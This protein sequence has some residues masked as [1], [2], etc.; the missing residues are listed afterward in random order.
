MESLRDTPPGRRR[1]VL[2]GVVIEVRLGD[3]LN[4]GQRPA[5]E[6]CH[7][8]LTPLDVLLQDRASAQTDALLQ[9]PAQLLR[10]WAMV[11]PMEEPLAM[12][13]TTAGRAVSSVRT[14]RLS[15]V[16]VTVCQRGVRT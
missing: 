11:T 3:D 6:H 10:V 1:L 2:V 8:D 4:G 7:L 13:F 12:G 9:A 5:V 15:A 14:S 16:T